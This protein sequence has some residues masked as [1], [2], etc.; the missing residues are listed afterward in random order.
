MF[1]NSKATLFQASDEPGVYE[2]AVGCKIVWSLSASGQLHRL[3]GLSTSNRAGNY[4]KP[5]P[6]YLKT[7]ALDRKER[8]WGIDLNRRLVSHKL[9]W[10]FILVL[11]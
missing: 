3:Q 2:L 1:R 4:W 11:A 8:L 10:H 5:V 7:I 6:L 9:C